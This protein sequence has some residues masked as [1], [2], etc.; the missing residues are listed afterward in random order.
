MSGGGGGGSSDSTSTTSSEPWVGQQP[1]LTDL[2]SNA[3]NLYHD[4]AN[5]PGFYP[6]TTAAP[7]TPAELSALQKQADVAVGPASYM[8]AQGA[9]AQ[10]F[11]L[12]PALMPQSNPAIQQAALGALTPLEWQL[13]QK[14]LPAIRSGAVEAGQYGGSR[15]GIAEANAIRDTLRTG[16]DTVANIFNNAYNTGLTAMVGAQRLTPDVVSSMF[17]PAQ[18]LGNVGSAQR[19]M[20]QSFYDQYVNR[21]NYNQNLPWEMLFNYRNAISGQPGGTTTTES[22]TD[23]SASPLNI[24]GSVGQL[25]MM[26]KIAGLFGV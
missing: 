7:F 15:Q 12:G 3:G 5:W 22:S 24:L 23:Q 17:M 26:G 20:D 1:Y 25:L 4:V 21:W 10:N 14:D 6:G 18:M 13:T 8:T 2:F 11:L 16:A 19:L 9:N